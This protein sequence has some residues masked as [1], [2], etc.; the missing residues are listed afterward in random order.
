MTDLNRYDR[1]FA[2]TAFAIQIVLLLYFALRTW[3]FDVA[4]RVGWVIYALGAPAAVVS[5]VLLAA[6]RPWYQALA[7]FLYTAWAIFGY[8]VDLARP[9]AWR[10]PIYW[11]VFVPY[12]LLYMGCQMFYW[13]PLGMLRRPFWF[14][15]GGLFVASTILNITSHGE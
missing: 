11:P 7:G 10:S 6:G 12:V 8:I 14:V 3:R 1:L 9:V 4:M 5:I 15:Y 2:I 13:W